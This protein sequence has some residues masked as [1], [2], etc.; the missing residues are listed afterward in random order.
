MAQP[1]VQSYAFG[2]NTSVKGHLA[3]LDDT[4]VVYPVGHMVA[5]LDTDTRVQRLLQGTIS[6]SGL[7]AMATASHRRHTAFA[8]GCG[9]R[10][11]HPHPI[12]TVYDWPNKRRKKTITSLDL[13]S[14]TVVSLSFTPDGKYLVAQGGSPEWSLC[15]VHWEKAKLAARY[16]G[17]GSVSAPIHQVD[18]S[19]YDAALFG[20]SG[21]GMFRL[22]RLA[23]GSFRPS[24]MVI[25]RDLPDCLCHAWLPEDRVVVGTSTGELLLFEGLELKLTLQTS[26]NDGLPIKSILACAKGFIVACGDATVRVYERSSDAREMFKRTRRYKIVGDDAQS[27]SAGGAGAGVPSGCGV[28]ELALTPSEDVLLCSL[29]NGQAYTLSLSNS[30]LLKPSDVRFDPLLTSFP[31]VGRSGG[32]AIT[33]M[34]VCLRKPIVVTTGV[35]RRVR[36]WNYGPSPSTKPGGDFLPVQEL[37]TLLDDDPVCIA[38]HPSGLHAA[39]AMPTHVRLMNILM[40]DIKTFKELAIKGVSEVR[41]STGGQ[42]LAVANSASV[43]VV[44][45]Y[46][47]EVHCVLRAHTERVTGLSWSPDDLVLYSSSL[48]GTICK[49]DVPSC[50]LAGSIPVP[51]CAVTGFWVCGDEGEGEG[52]ELYVVGEHSG[53]SSAAP[54]RC[55]SAATGDVKAD[56]DL[57][58]MQMGQV[59]VSSVNKIVLCA[60]SHPFRIGVLRAYKLPLSGEF[61]DYVSAG[62]PITRVCLSP[63]GAVV[64]AAAVDGSISFFT[65]PLYGRWSGGKRDK[66]REGGV[67][68]AEEILVTKSDLE[69]SNLARAELQAKVSELTLQH[70]YRLRV[71]D[72]N[73]AEKVK[74]VEDKFGQELSGDRGRHSRLLTD[75]EAMEAVY[76][77]KID[78]FE[79]RQA[80]EL[81]ELESTYKAKIAGEIDRYDTL[82]S[83]R[84]VMAAAWDRANAAAIAAH[85]SHVQ[86]LLAEHEKRVADEEALIRDLEL[87]KSRM[88]TEIEVRSGLAEKDADQELEQLR[89]KYGAKLAVEKRNTLLLKGENGI[90]RKKFSQLNKELN[91]QKEELRALREKEKETSDVIRGLDKDILGHKKEMRER[92]ETVMDKDKRIYDLRKKNQELEKFKFVLNYKIQELKRQIMPKKKEI[93]DMRD[94]TKEMQVELTQYYKSNAALDLMIGE[95]R[96]KREGLQLDVDKVSELCAQ[97]Q[98]ATRA[99]RQHVYDA[100]SRSVDDK[101]L[102]A[103]INRLYAMY[104]LKEGSIV[105][106]AVTATGSPE[107]DAQAENARQR[108]YL[109][110]TLASVASKR[111]KAALLHSQDRSKLLRDNAVLL[112][113]INGLRRELR[114]LQQDIACVDLGISVSTGTL[115]LTPPPLA[116]PSKQQQLIT[117][118]R[119]MSIGGVL[120]A[121]PVSG[122]ATARSGRSN[123]A[124][125]VPTAPST[126]RSHDG[127]VRELDMQRATMAQLQARVDSLRDAVSREPLLGRAVADGLSQP[128]ALEDAQGYGRRPDSRNRALTPLAPLPL[129]PSSPRLGPSGTPTSSRA[130]T[131]PHPAPS[132]SP[133]AAD[134]DAGARVRTFGFAGNTPRSEPATE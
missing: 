73:Y 122:D 102:K 132:P 38:L 114:S 130:L 65:T 56:V 115:S 52:K 123:S 67:E 18:G 43:T 79:R 77:A 29:D 48:D 12:L 1:L 69:D 112:E 2:L 92:D 129:H 116:K 40:D 80:K 19:P 127:M 13:G 23:E 10:E 70:N 7:C 97:A 57:S 66:E 125:T 118:A 128:L 32:K 76:E 107:E 49:W 34:D 74:E 24:S 86:R 62:G 131:H 89:T 42:Y 82:I 30:E 25:K 94:Q 84:D 81:E 88:L 58:G 113:E 11:R 103:E 124:V 41:F 108:S 133:P 44:C 16:N 78:A 31:S 61:F 106:V 27:P 75:K 104:I 46:S 87:E 17:L 98:T 9:D 105:K 109:E 99:M 39:V 100:A 51:G 14:S 101:T 54:F 4:D 90:M 71:K 134:A 5:R 95:L 6:S 35:D 121:P 15:L 126:T 33:G 68:W 21:M 119:N 117:V 83:S 28:C 8:E 64:A 53:G 50:K 111:D 93:Q 55:V 3:Y 63:D 36:V 60:S 85:T 20:V 120:V 45:T 110:R 91:D 72:L 22:L 26:P 47:V 59:V 37:T 96:L